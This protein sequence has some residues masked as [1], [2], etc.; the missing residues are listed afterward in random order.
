VA[1]PCAWEPPPLILEHFQLRRWLFLGCG[2]LGDDAVLWG[3]KIVNRSQL[4]SEGRAERGAQVGATRL[5]TTP[6][7]LRDPFHVYAHRFSVFVP[8]AR[9]RGADQR[10]AL[11]RLIAGET[12]AHAQGSVEYV[13]PRFRIGGL[14]SIGLDAVVGRYPRGVELDAT[15]LGPASVLE[16]GAAAAGPRIGASARL[17]QR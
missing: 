8:A 9:V 6:D 13:E 12:P 17:E 2:R 7:P 10:R 14:S 3:Q 15:R 1:P 5:V 4:T 16:G 11:E